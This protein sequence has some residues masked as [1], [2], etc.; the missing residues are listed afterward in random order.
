[1]RL[2]FKQVEIELLEPRDRRAR[3][4]PRHGFGF[5]FLVAQSWW[6]KQMNKSDIVEGDVD[7]IWT[8]CQWTNLHL[9]NG[10]ITRQMNVTAQVCV[11]WL[12]T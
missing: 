2:V 4:T 12:C 1:M 10:R 7:D 11:G 6:N 9:S 5:V 8:N 3:Q